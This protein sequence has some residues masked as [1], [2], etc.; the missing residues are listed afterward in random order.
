MPRSAPPGGPHG[1]HPPCD[2]SEISSRAS[3]SKPSV[4]WRLIPGALS[5][6][7][8]AQA[9]AAPGGITWRGQVSGTTPVRRKRSRLTSAT[10]IGGLAAERT[11]R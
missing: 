10:I 3:W 7:A 6:L 11:V 8:C 2:E 4:A 1:V 5:Q 9:T